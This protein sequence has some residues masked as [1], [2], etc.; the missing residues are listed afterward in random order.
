MSDLH[1]II[2]TCTKRAYDSGV[3]AQRNNVVK[4]LESI[5]KETTCTCTNCEQWI[6]AFEFIIAKLDGKING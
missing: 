4:L 1:E 6:N 3:N 2:A 5:K